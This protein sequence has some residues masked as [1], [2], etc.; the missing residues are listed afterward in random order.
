MLDFFISGAIAAD[1]AVDAAVS[2]GS[3]GIEG[4]LFPIG[5]IIV[6][7]FLLIRPQQ[8]K[9]KEHKKLIEEVQK[10][11]EVVSGGGVLGKVTDLGDHFVTLEIADNVYIKLMKTSISTVMP[12]GTYKSEGKPSKASKKESKQIENK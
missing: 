12:K 10:G 3:P 8:K 6:F 5:L 11:D 2:A 4:L 7:Y 1:G 9:N